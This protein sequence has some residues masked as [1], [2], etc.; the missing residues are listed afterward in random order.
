MYC[1]ICGAKI[2][3][4]E[5]VNECPECLCTFEN[6]D[7]NSSI[8]EF[9]SLI[10]DGNIVKKISPDD[11]FMSAMVEL[12][13]KDLIEYQLKIQQFKNQLQQ[14][15]LVKMQEKMVVT[16]NVP[17]CPTCDSTNIKKISTISKAGSVAIWGI[18]SRKVH[19]QWHCNNC[20]S[21]W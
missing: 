14:Q 12:Y 7:P 1:D 9:K 4:G 11:S 17:H 18:F 3:N 16:N 13:E 19:K 15:D 8:K 20:G 2:E 6:E 21:E 10:P 5:N